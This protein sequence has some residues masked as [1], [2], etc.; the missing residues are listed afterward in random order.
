MQMKTSNL[1]SICNHDNY[2][3]FYF[4]NIIHT[5]H[6]LIGFV[7]KGK[8]DT[9]CTHFISYQRQQTEESQA[10]FKTE[11]PVRISRFF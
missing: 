8:V 3:I 7:V 5:E 6:L 2:R 4:G 9:L 10:A 11:N 1:A